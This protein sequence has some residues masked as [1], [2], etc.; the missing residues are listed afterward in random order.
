VEI[1]KKELIPE[2]AQPKHGNPIVKAPSSNLGCGMC[3]D[4][5]HTQLRW[6]NPILIFRI[7]QPGIY[8]N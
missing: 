4:G 8:S 6:I 7:L 2:F 3:S 1:P 5:G